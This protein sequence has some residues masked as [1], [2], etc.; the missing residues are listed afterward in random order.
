MSNRQVRKNPISIFFLVAIM[1][2]ATVVLAILVSK[3]S[4]DFI[5]IF[6]FAVL[7]VMEMLVLIDCTSKIRIIDNKYIE[8]REIFIKKRELISDIELIKREGIYIVIYFKSPNH[9]KRWLI[10]YHKKLREFLNQFW[11]K[12]VETSEV[13]F[14][15]SKFE[16]VQMKY[17]VLSFVSLWMGFIPFVILV[18]DD[19]TK[20]LGYIIGAVA[21]IL[22]CLFLLTGSQTY[23]LQDNEIIRRRYLISR[24][25]ITNISKIKLLYKNGIPWRYCIYFDDISKKKWF[26]SYNNR[27]AKFIQTFWK[28]PID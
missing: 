12:P 1:L 11:K 25:K 28:K 26:L 9:K 23:R 3:D 17:I 5:S 19:G 8:G 20:T 7:F 27:S 16:D 4:I 10:F 2:P 6:P 14:Y 22:F 13:I 15:K 18:I 21:I 24:E